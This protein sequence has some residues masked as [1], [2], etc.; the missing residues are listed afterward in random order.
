MA[1]SIYYN[2]KLANSITELPY[3]KHCEWKCRY[4]WTGGLRMDEQGFG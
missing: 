4:Y 1:V 2:E 3:I